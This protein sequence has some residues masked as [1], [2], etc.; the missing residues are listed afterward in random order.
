MFAGSSQFSTAAERAGDQIVD[1]GS[2]NMVGSWEELPNFWLTVAKNAFVGWTLNFR[3]R[4]LLKGAVN[5]FKLFLLQWLK[6][7]I[8]VSLKI[9]N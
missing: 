7:T 9:V 6:Y 4:V 5:E 8:F 2:N 3:V 1:H